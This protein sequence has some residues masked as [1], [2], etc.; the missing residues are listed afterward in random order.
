MVE[1]PAGSGCRMTVCKP[2]PSQRPAA[3]SGEPPGIRRGGTAPRGG[4]P[5]GVREREHG[6]HAAMVLLD[7][8]QAQ[9]LEDARAVLLH[10]ALADAEAL[11][12]APVR[13]AVG[14]QLE[15]LALASGQLVERPFAAALAEQ[16]A[17]DRRI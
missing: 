10:L 3:V 8:G 5:S 1:V 2:G 7:S 6:E 17:D 12:D 13:P 15:H 14:H 4:P 9:L 16:L 11:G